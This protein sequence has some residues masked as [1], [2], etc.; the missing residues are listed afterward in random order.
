MV[1]VVAGPG[2]VGKGTVVKRLVEQDPSL[3]LSRSWTTRG[4]RPGEPHH[5]YHWATRAE[6]EARI[7]EGG[8]LEYA[9]FLGNYY[10]T[11]V[12]GPEAGDRDVVLEIDVQGAAQIVHRDPGVFLI[13]ITA[14]SADEQEA[15]L[16]KRG[17]PD[18]KVAQRLAVAR[19]E[20]AQ[21]EQLG[22]RF[23]INDILDETVAEL[24]AI[25]DEA[26]RPAD[27]G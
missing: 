26:R 24:A 27:Q 14:P 9:E 10:G 19:E 13:F 12:P 15:R 20:T 16:R 2:G 1:I 25:I 8:F 18:D 7:A 5:A 21:A 23:V 4:R 11:P 6:F 22:A 17:D 3:W